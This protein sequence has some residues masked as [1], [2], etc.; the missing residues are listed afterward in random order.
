M[1][2]LV[3]C[4]RS[5]PLLILNYQIQF[6]KLLH[7]WIWLV[8]PKVSENKNAFSVS[9]QITPLTATNSEGWSKKR[10]NEEHVIVYEGLNLN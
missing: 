2:I 3:K 10:E 1:K 8:F 9:Q 6:H 4:Y 7:Y 5:F